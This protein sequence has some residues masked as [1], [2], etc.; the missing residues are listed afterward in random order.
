[1]GTEENN[2]DVYSG[3]ISTDSLV[4]TVKKMLGTEQFDDLVPTYV[5]IAQSAILNRLYPMCTDKTWDDVGDR[6]NARVCEIAVYLVNKR[7]AEGE[8]AHKENGTE[9]TYASASVPNAML[10]D[11][12]PYVRVLDV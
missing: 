11:I 4:D 9:R 8:T 5:A 7:G 12:V 2:V 6:Y 1:M 3:V 10:A